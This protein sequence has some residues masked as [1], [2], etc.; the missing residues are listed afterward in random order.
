M[1]RGH[2]DDNPNEFY[3]AIY[4]HILNTLSEEV[5]LDEVTYL[6]LNFNGCTVEV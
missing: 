4:S 3:S 5:L 6:I 2:Q 1:M